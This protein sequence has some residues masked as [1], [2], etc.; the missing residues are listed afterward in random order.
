MVPAELGTWLVAGVAG[1]TVTALR[2]DVVT[3]VLGVFESA[4]RY[5]IDIDDVHGAGREDLLLSAPC[6]PSLPT[7]PGIGRGTEQGPTA[8]RTVHR[9]C[10]WCGRVVPHLQRP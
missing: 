6:I 10:A 1:A 4:R 5:R 7:H 9:Q 2:N 3:V 8:A